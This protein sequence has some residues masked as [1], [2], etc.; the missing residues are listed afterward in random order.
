MNCDLCGG[1]F[2]AM[3]FRS[4]ADPKDATFER[5]VDYKKCNL[6]GSGMVIYHP[7][8]PMYKIGKESLPLFPNY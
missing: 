6:C 1:S 3:G 7:Y 2:E 4:E 8:M 5:I